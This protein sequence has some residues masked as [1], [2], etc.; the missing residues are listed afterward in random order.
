MATN[1]PDPSQSP[2]TNPDNGIIYEYDNGIWIPQ[3]SVGG[4][5]GGGEDGGG[6]GGILLR[7]N[8]G[9]FTYEAWT[10]TASD[11]CF[12]IQ[13][14]SKYSY[15]GNL[16]ISGKDKNGNVNSRTT[17][18]TG[19]LTVLIRTMDGSLKDT[20]SNLGEHAAGATIKGAPDGQTVGTLQLAHSSIGTPGRYTVGQDY[21]LESDY[22]FPYTS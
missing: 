2:W 15:K 10:G 7:N 3:S 5:G 18:Y 17:N 16:R 11:G 12:Q 8:T 9:V 6:G 19:F 22:I 4:D 14:H 20:M 13:Q 21:I 1:F